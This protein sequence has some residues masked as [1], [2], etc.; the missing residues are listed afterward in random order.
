MTRIGNGNKLCLKRQ[1]GVT[2][3]KGDLFYSMAFLLGSKA[4][5]E[6]FTQHYFYFLLIFIFVLCS[7]T[8]RRAH[9]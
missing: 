9:N 7:V 3:G 2:L 5:S 8:H 4:T 1:K 6:V